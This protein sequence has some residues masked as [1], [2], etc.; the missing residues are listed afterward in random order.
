MRRIS[1]TYMH[2]RENVIL[3]FNRISW[4]ITILKKCV[5]LN[6]NKLRQK[7][8][9]LQFLNPYFS[10]VSHLFLTFQHCSLPFLY[11]VYLF[12]PNKLSGS[13][14]SCAFRITFLIFPYFPNISLLYLTIHDFPKCSSTNNVFG[15]RAL[16]SLYK[17][18]VNYLNNH[19][20]SLFSQKSSKIAH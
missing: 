15:I 4:Q 6:C 20:C 13:C 3:S 19:H 14:T 12:L 8:V 9:N 18:F 5:N 16:P 7:R 17:N 11:L 10:L 1:V 2:C